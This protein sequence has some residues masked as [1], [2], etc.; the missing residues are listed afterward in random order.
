VRRAII[1]SVVGAV[2]ASALV[3]LAI[4]VRPGDRE[5]A[6]DIYVLALGALAMLSISRVARVAQRS[7]ARP[8]E[9]DEAMAPQTP[10]SERPAELVRLE[11]EVALAAARAFDLHFKL[12]PI[13]REIA[14]HRLESRRGI[15]PDADESAARAL[16]G[17]PAWELLR[18]D[19]PAPEDRMAAG[20]PLGDLR[21]VVDSLEKI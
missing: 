8:S 2:C 11:R 10:V 9:F 4:S 16:L 1:D 17:D 21:G 19:R 12:R 6:L 14:D 20:M 15:A 3:A 18:E 7:Q 5:L 13:L